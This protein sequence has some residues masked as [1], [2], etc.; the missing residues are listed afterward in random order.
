MADDQMM[1]VTFHRI[2]FSGATN[3]S[4]GRSTELPIVPNY[5]AHPQFPHTSHDNYREE[6]PRVET[7]KQAQVQS[8]SSLHSKHTQTQPTDDGR[9]F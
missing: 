3:G 4:S 5:I 7:Q 6:L 8:R 2:T 9:L 1:E